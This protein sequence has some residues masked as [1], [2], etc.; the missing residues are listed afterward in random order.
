MTNMLRR[1]R[2]A[3]VLLGA[4]DRPNFKRVDVSP[5]VYDDGSWLTSNS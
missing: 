4:E 3:V 1:F 5:V 2:N